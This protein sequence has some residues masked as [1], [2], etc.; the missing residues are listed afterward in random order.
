MFKSMKCTPIFPFIT[1]VETLEFDG[2]PIVCL[3][4]HFDPIYYSDTL[5]VKL[6]GRNL[7]KKVS[8]SV[9][10]RKAEFLAGRVLA[11]SILK[12]LEHTNTIVDIGN[13]RAPVWPESVKGSISHADQVAVCAICRDSLYK[14][15]GIDIEPLNTEVSESLKQSIISPSEI[16]LL[17]KCGFVKSTAFSLAFSAKESL[18]KAI[19]P[20]VNY[21]FDFDSATL[22]HINT[23][24]KTF[25]ISLNVDL[26]ETF[27]KGMKFYGKYILTG[28]YILTLIV[29]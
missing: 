11:I 16:N 26:N 9:H 7:Y 13:Q 15:I 23:S 22:T 10:N 3:K 19:F 25:K 17:N 6:L 5:A 28:G 14:R 2:I 12:Q 20:E 4:C 1:A 24:E 8:G 29:D 18:F 27:K 21:Y